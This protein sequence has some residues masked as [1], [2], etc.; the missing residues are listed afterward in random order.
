[1]FIKCV[2]TAMKIRVFILSESF[3][4]NLRLVY[5]EKSIRKMSDSTPVV[6]KEVVGCTC[7]R[8]SQDSSVNFRIMRRD[9]GCRRRRQRRCA[10]T[11]CTCVHVKH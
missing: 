7:I 2:S 9:G 11:H 4:V 8:E 10:L 6:Y 1:M 5:T 3:K